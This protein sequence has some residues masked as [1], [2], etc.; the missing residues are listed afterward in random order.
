MI[1]RLIF[2]DIERADKKI[3]IS[4]DTNTIYV[5]NLSYIII[6]LSKVAMLVKLKEP[7]KFIVKT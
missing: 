2:K 6:F 3:N 7:F 4:R 1:S 5:C